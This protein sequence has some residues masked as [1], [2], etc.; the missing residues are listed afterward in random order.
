MWI[1]KYN[2]PKFEDYEVFSTIESCLPQIKVIP[3][4]TIYIRGKNIKEA[5]KKVY[6]DYFFKDYLKLGK[7][8][9]NLAHRVICCDA[10]ILN[11][12]KLNT[13]Y[14]SE[15]GEISLNK[16]EQ[17]I[18]NSY[19]KNIDNLEKQLE[20]C[21]SPSL[22]F[23]TLDLIDNIFVFIMVLNTHI[24]IDPNI[25]LTKI[26]EILQKLDKEKIE[27]DK[28]SETQKSLN[29][30]MNELV[31][32]SKE[33]NF[34][35]RRYVALS[36]TKKIDNILNVDVLNYS[37]VPPL[38]IYYNDEQ[39]PKL[40]EIIL[41]WLNINGFPYFV[42]PKKEQEYLDYINKKVEQESIND[43]KEYQDYKNK[44]KSNNK[45][46]IIP[47]ENLIIHS[48]STYLLY[49]ILHQQMKAPDNIKS[50][51]SINGSNKKQLNLNSIYKFKKIVSYYTKSTCNTIDSFIIQPNNII[52]YNEE[53]YEDNHFAESYVKFNNLCIAA[54]LLLNEST[55]KVTWKK[56]KVCIRCGKHI[57]KGYKY[58]EKCR[59]E[60]RNEYK[61]LKARERRKKEKENNKK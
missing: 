60:S 58:C 24:D 49:T 43:P 31:N 59:K 23:E 16:Y 57:K 44:S 52:D 4:D 34:N 30:L 12:I 13:C 50:F 22:I 42:I 37:K 14:F 6:Y 38:S 41:E 17:R 8:L 51:Y 20:N 27:E 28:I 46:Y 48:V 7:K 18:L 11:D 2:L 47:C 15:S 45:N 21:D 26:I 29:I 56:Y 32:L 9:Y 1:Y 10:E 35:L 36:P 19:Q 40:K 25:Y 33:K 3:L 61:K 53:E 5:E 39:F 54:N 55:Q